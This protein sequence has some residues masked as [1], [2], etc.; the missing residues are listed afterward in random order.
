[1]TPFKTVKNDF[2]VTEYYREM[3]FHYEGNPGWGFSF[4][5]DENGNVNVNSLHPAGLD[6]YE[7]CLRGFTSDGTKIIKGGIEEYSNTYQTCPCGSG[8]FRE[9]Q[10]DGRGI[11]L[12]FCCEECREEKLKGVNPVVLGSY[13]EEDVNYER[14]EPLD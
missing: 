9:T 10:N 6:N 3:K 1:M 11:F 4:P 14:I 13:S 7:M 2:S 5:C 12:F 8:E